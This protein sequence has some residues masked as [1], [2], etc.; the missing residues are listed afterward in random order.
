MIPCPVLV[1]SL[2]TY[3]R[4]RELMTIEAAYSIRP[5]EGLQ[6]L[7]TPNQ[8]SR[9][10]LELRPRVNKYFEIL[11]EEPGTTQLS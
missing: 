10:S 2:L 5:I 7:P 6:F 11:G 4:D 1:Q 9:D 8:C 3:L